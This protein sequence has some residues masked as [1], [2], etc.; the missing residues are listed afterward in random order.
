MG[1]LG[2]LMALYEHF[3][4]QGI[5][6]DVLRQLGKDEAL[7]VVGDLIRNGNNDDARKVMAGLRTLRNNSNLVVGNLKKTDS[8]IAPLRG[9][10][11]LSDSAMAETA[12][13]YLSLIH[14]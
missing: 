9:V 1:D 7:F 4:P 5:Y 14:I 10:M 11:N 13:L 3:E 6:D 2:V 12:E 8:F